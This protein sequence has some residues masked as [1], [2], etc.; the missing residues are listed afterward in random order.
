MT[1][2]GAAGSTG[3]GGAGQAGQAGHVGQAGQ[4]GQAGNAGG[5]GGAGGNPIFSPPGCGARLPAYA[6]TLC[7]PASLPCQTLVDETVETTAV[8]R[9][10]QPAIATDSSGQPQ[11]IYYSAAGNYVGI[12]AIRSPAGVW[13]GETFPIAVA[14]ASL[15]VGA[16]GLPVGLVN[17]GILPGTSLWRRGSGGWIRLDGADLG[18]YES[19]DT[20]ALVATQDGCFHAGLL[21]DVNGNAVYPGY[22][23]WNGRWNLT[24]FGYTS[25]GGVP[26]A[27]ALAADGTPYVAYWSYSS[28]GTGGLYLS[29][30]GHASELLDHADGTQDWPMRAFITVTAD[31]EG[32]PVPHVLYRAVGAAV[33]GGAAAPH[34]LIEAERAASGAWTKRTVATASGKTSADC[35]APAR[36]SG[37]C[38]IDFTDVTPV[39]IVGTREGSTRLLYTAD[40]TTAT[41]VSVCMG[42]LDGAP[43]TCSYQSQMTTHDSEL[44]LA[45]S[46]DDGSI[47]QTVV[48]RSKVAGQGELAAS[49]T[50]DVLG[51]IHVGLFD[52]VSDTVV[53]YVLVGGS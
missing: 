21:A 34:V 40:H 23:L 51:R 39:A 30:R 7:G 28:Q 1:G 20:G 25:V 45:W 12:W 6:G 35:P 8:F 22:A 10:R 26:A 27:V 46:N 32:Q 14:S 19:Y 15:V 50:L 38:A 48:T 43:T 2:A 9:N 24:S 33:A 18:G 31:G 52:G 29:W 11:M 47:G 37:S 41:L 13:Q 5:L 4:T 3:G 16:D 49:A 17:S 53:R 44:R 42:G 36:S